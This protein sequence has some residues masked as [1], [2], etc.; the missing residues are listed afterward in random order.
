MSQTRRAHEAQRGFTLVE[1]S[2]LLAV[3]VI[4]SAVI[5][6]VLSRSV[7]ETRISAAKAELAAISQALRQ[8]LE[9]IGCEIVPQN[10]G[11]GSYRRAGAVQAPYTTPPEALPVGGPSAELA[12]ASGAWSTCGSAAVCNSDPVELLV[13]SGDIP[14][15]G[16]DG[17]ERWVQPPDGADVDFLEF[18]LISNTPGDTSS[19]RFPTPEDCADPLSSLFDEVQ[20]WRGAYLS[21]GH[22]DPWGNRYMINT[23]YLSG[24]SVE[25]VV[26]LSAGPDQ[27]VDSDFAVD[28]FV[29]DDDDVALLFSTGH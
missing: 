29:P 26:V 23:L 2:I 6:P 4:L 21:V 15:L 11:D 19:R 8:F 22:G 24:R 5:T 13:S 17:D 27:E 18:Y 9:D 3:L 28:G 7:A 1:V 14:A 16:P 25:D 12:R 20:A 10:Q